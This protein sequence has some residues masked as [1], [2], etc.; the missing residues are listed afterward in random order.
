[1]S[2]DTFGILTILWFGSMMVITILG[3]IAI[4]LLRDIVNRLPSP[5][6]GTE[7][8]KEK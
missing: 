8:K 4:D 6:L 7:P 3:A 5:K 2:D 1:M